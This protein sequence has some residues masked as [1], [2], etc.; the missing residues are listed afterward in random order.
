MI[1]LAIT[2]HAPT[3]SFTIVAFGGSSS[4]IRIGR[5]VED[6][7]QVITT[8]H[9]VSKRSITL[10]IWTRCSAIFTGVIH[11]PSQSMSMT[12]S[13]VCCLDHNHC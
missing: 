12:G 10:V 6:M 4:L 1:T 7:A 11:I 2:I 13:S 8:I 9:A 3:S 5:S